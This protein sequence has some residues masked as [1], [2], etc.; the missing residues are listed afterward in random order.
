MQLLARLAS[1]ALCAGAARA[2]AIWYV[3]ASAPPGGNGTSWARAYRELHL[4]LGVADGGDQVW[5]ARGSYYPRAAAGATDP[6]TA[7]FFVGPGISLYGGFAGNEVSLGQ[8]AGLHAST[9][10]SGD[11]GVRGDASD[12]AYHVVRTWGDASIDGFTITGGNGYGIPGAN[13]GGIFCDIGDAGGGLYQ[14]SGLT[15]RNCTVARNRSARGGGLFGQLASLRVSLCTFQDNV[16]SGNGGAIALQTSEARIDLTVFRRNSCEGQGGALQLVSIGT[17]GGLNGRPLVQLFGCLLHD[18]YAGGN[19]GAAFMG[20]GNYNSGKGVFT[21]CTIAAN[22]AGLAGGGL[23]V[24]SSAATPGV[25][26]LENTIVSSN[27]APSDPDLAGAHGAWHSIAPGQTGPGV[28]NVAP[29]F[30]SLAL[31]DFRVLPSSPAVDA[32]SDSLLLPDALDVDGDGSLFEFVP[33]DLDL[34][35]RVMGLRVDIGAYEL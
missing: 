20:G 25:S 22:G 28:L 17:S 14:G 6:R 9:V 2:Q 24:A 18:N 15:L 33:I 8:R 11:I 7:E 19:G 30:A 32:G 4:A 27:R 29:R 21:S 12:N 13:G 10:L 34:N 26:W 5:V 3:D 23:F 35:P 31:R 1:L 16:A